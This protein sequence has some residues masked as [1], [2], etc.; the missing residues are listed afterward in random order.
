MKIRTISFLLFSTALACAFAC[1]APAEEG[2]ET[3]GIYSDGKGNSGWIEVDRGGGRMRA[4]P[5]LRISGETAREVLQAAGRGGE[6]GQS[7]MRGMQA[8]G[9]PAAA[10]PTER[11]REALSSLLEGPEGVSLA[12]PLD[13]VKKASD[14]LKRAARKV[15]KETPVP[16]IQAKAR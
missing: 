5:F 3:I 4:T 13:L 12:G 8:Q 16:S 6:A 9:D 14:S 11:K 2:G 7:V 10:G 1:P 15:R